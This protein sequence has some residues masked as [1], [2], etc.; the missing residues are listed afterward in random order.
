M[1]AKDKHARFLD[2]APSVMNFSDFLLR[3]EV[4]LSRS[5]KLF[6]FRAM[7]WLNFEAKD[8]NELL[9]LLLDDGLASVAR[10]RLDPVIEEGAAVANPNPKSICVCAW[11]RSVLLKALELQVISFD[12]RDFQA[13]LEQLAS[14]I[15]AALRVMSGSEALA[16]SCREVVDDLKQY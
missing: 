15:E 6:R 14:T 10:A 2:P 7:F 12:M 4:G 13:N 1:K 16:E 9:S 5:F 11:L 8:L 3:N